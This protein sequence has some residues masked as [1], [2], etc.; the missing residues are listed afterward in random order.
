MPGVPTNQAPQAPHRLN[1]NFNARGDTDRRPS[2][3]KSPL[4]LRQAA[5]KSPQSEMNN[6]S[7]KRAPST[8]SRGSSPPKKRGRIGPPS[9]PRSRTG[10]GAGL[11]RN[12]T[13]GPADQRAVRAVG[14]QD[15]GRRSSAILGPL[16]VQSPVSRS[17]ASTPVQNAPLATSMLPKHA[18]VNVSGKASLA[19]LQGLKFRKEAVFNA[20]KSQTDDAASISTLASQLKAKASEND[21]LSERVKALEEQ[22]EELRKLDMANIISR[23]TNLAPPP[24]KGEPEAR[25]TEKARTEL[26]QVSKPLAAKVGAL[27]NFK[28]S[29]EKQGLPSQLQNL[30]RVVDAVVKN[31]RK[32]YEKISQHI[33]DTVK[34]LGP[35]GWEY[36]NYG[37][38]L[39]E[40]VKK[41]DELVPLVRSL[42]KQQEN[43]EIEQKT[44]QGR[45]NVFETDKE[46]LQGR[47]TLFQTQKKDLDARVQRLDV[48]ITSLEE[49]GSSGPGPGFSKDGTSVASPSTNA[50]PAQ[51][52]TVKTQLKKLSDDV[53][54]LQSSLTETDSLRTQIATL[55][56]KTGSIEGKVNTVSDTSNRVETQMAT[57]LSK[58][59]ADLNKDVQTLFDGLTTVEDIVHN[60]TGMIEV[61]EH[62]VP[63]IFAR[64]MDPFKQE[65]NKKIE[66]LTREVTTSK[67]QPQHVSPPTS[68]E[69]LAKLKQEV[70]QLQTEVAEHSLLRERRD[71]ELVKLIASADSGVESLRLSFRVL[72]DQY[73]NISSD[74]LHGKMVQWFLQAYPSN[75]ANMVQQFVAL[76]QDIQNIQHLFHQQNDPTIKA[77]K[78]AIDGIQQSLRS[79][80]SGDSP[81]ASTA[82]VTKLS[83]QVT[84]LDEKMKSPSTAASTEGNKRLQDIRKI[85]STCTALASRVD[86]VEGAETILRKEV[87]TIK[88][89]FMEPH[90]GDLASVGH[91]IENVIAVQKTVKMISERVATKPGQQLPLI[92]W[93]NILG[94]GGPDTAAAKKG[95]A[96]K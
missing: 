64:T 4:S 21:Q 93:P 81:F 87:D 17:G 92:E 54:A 13:A 33:D 79:L 45:Q 41:L 56:E 5:T 48:R 37:T 42:Q 15:A 26:D 20:S 40:Q 95:K 85:E 43:S 57:L 46:T 10:S 38:T 12:A 16:H 67:Q 9:P 49:K 14:D 91:M 77:M 32:T 61:L 11:P 62:E 78:T 18:S 52:A 24:A 86:K 96:K 35:V 44:L 90:R 30:S 8:R 89:D 70:A 36:G 72:Q 55:S 83:A 80:N 50:I 73:N 27:E 68:S 74:E 51:D 34:Y 29:M 7:L 82:A 63:K 88:N 60:H 75:A 39:A 25:A 76:R 3:L 69:E 6:R 59:L 2:H 1:T 53:Q 58:T 71:Q 23:L 31:E 94:D 28:T 84:A 65:V 19:S 47:Q 22:V 66:E